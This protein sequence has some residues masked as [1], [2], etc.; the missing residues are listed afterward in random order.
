VLA[1]HVVNRAHLSP[2]PPSRRA[3]PAWS[4]SRRSTRSAGRRR[5]E[6][7]LCREPSH[8]PRGTLAPV[9]TPSG[10]LG[11]ASEQL[12]FG[13][14]RLAPRGLTRSHASASG[15]LDLAGDAEPV[16]CSFG[17]ARRAEVDQMAG[18]EFEVAR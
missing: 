12:T 1:E 16:R 14:G 11:G 6:V 5:A 3:G 4:R 9:V 17:S 8:R 10:P 18:D 13:A 2:L 15:F 7:A